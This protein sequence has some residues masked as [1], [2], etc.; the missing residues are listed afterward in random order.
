MRM[1]LLIKTHGT[2]YVAND[3]LIKMKGLWRKGNSSL[4]TT[5]SEKNAG[6]RDT[7]NQLS[8]R[9]ERWFGMEL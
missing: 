7:E 3:F 2:F 5:S 8:L 9:V 4:T 1:W 6:E